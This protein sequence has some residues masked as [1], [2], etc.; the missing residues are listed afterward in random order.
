M[1]EQML[2]TDSKPRDELLILAYSD[3]KLK[4]CKKIYTPFYKEKEYNGK[5]NIGSHS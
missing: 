2:N 1:F 3:V 5:F 4:K